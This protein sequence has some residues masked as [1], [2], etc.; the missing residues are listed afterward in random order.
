MGRRFIERP[1]DSVHDAVESDAPSGMNLRIEE[2]F[3]EEEILV[4][5]FFQLRPSEIVKLPL[6]DKD[7]CPLVIT[8]QK[9]LQISEPVGG[10]KFVNGIVFESYAVSGGKFE[11]EFRLQRAVDI[12]MQ[13]GLRLAFDKVG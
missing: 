5:D 3:R 9:I 8:L 11:T 1:A 6:F 2:Y 7:I 10:A 13:F 4:M 12:N